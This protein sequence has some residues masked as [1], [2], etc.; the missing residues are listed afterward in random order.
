M[1]PSDLDIQRT[2]HLWIQQHGDNATAKARERGLGGLRSAGGQDAG[3][4]WFRSPPA[5]AL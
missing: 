4:S 5:A 1:S 2:A 3:R